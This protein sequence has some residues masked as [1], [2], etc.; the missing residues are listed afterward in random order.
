[1]EG[2]GKNVLIIGGTGFLGYHAGLELLRRGYD[3]TALAIPDIELKEWFPEQIPLIYSDIFSIGNDELSKHLDGFDS[4][5]YAMGPDDRSVPDAPADVFFKEKLVQTSARIFEAARL[6]G[7]KRAVLLGSYF[8][9]FHR[10]WPHLKLDK[11]HPYIRARIRQ[12]Q[13]VLVASGSEMETMILELPYIFGTMPGRIPLWK[14][15][16]FDRLLKM[17]PV[18]YPDGGSSMICVE[19]VAEAIAG[20]IAHGK[21]GA[22]YPIGDLDIRWK[23][24]FA[25]MFTAIGV[26]RRFIHVPHWIAALAGRVMMRRNRKM[27]KEPGLHLGHVF[28]D[29]ISRDFFLESEHSAGVL[30]YGSGDVRASIAKTA[31]ACYPSGY[32][33]RAH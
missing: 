25:I 1:M 30:G 7:I 10:K 31:K 14:E 15:V 29:I 32:S 6:A 8:S 19:N 23:E 22:R 24:M 26:R 13:A 2:K 4:L 11:K 28:K 16:F 9:Y 5:V 17:N 18:L 3:V 21:A 27:G 33:K 20:A 12:A